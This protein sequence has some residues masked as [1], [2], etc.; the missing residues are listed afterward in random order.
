[1]LLGTG[2]I[3]SE[4]F[5][6][7][8]TGIFLLR[9]YVKIGAAM[10][11]KFQ[12]NRKGKK[13]V[14]VLRKLTESVE[15]FVRKE[16]KSGGV[17][18]EEK[19][20]KGISRFSVKKK[21]R[22]ELRREKRK[23]KKI[24]RKTYCEGKRTGSIKA[25]ETEL[26][27]RGKARSPQRKEFNEVEK[28]IPT[29]SELIR[30]K[31]KGKAVEKGQKKST[32]LESSKR[33]EQLKTKKKSGGRLLETRRLALL[34]ANAEEDRE[35]K[36]L[37]KQLR[38]N[39]RKN[40]K[41]LPQSFVADGLDYVLGILEP[42]AAG[43]GLYES[44]EETE[45][46]G[47]TLNEL[48]G[49]GYDQ[50]E[51]EESEMKSDPEDSELSENEETGESDVDGW[52]EFKQEDSAPS[53]E[54]QNILTTTCEREESKGFPSAQGESEDI[55]MNSGQE[56][57]TE[58]YIPPHLQRS[59]ETIDSKRRE[60]LDRLKRS[61]KGLINRLSEANIA[62]ISSQFEELYMAHS[63]KD[64]NDTLTDVLLVS[65]VI[66]SLMP[67][68]L[69]MEHVLLISIL[70][71]TVGMEVGAHF[72]ETIVRKFDVFHLSSSEGKESDNLL[73]MIAHMYNFN[74]VHCVLMFD[75]LKK[76]LK[77]FTEKDIELI[78]F[79]L[80]NVGFSLRKDDPLALKEVI[81][82]IQCKA[83]SLA[84]RMQEQ[85]RVRF[86]L[87]TLLA[88][89]NNDMRKIPGYDPEPVDRL[90]KLQRTLIHNNASGSDVCLR[91]TLDSLL[92][93]DQVG[94]WWI[95][96]SSWSGAPMLNASDIKDKEI[97]SVGK[98]SAKI[99]E[100]A[101]KQRMNT[102]IRRNIFCVLMT[103]EDFLDA[104]EKLLRLGLK[105]HQQRE[106]VHVLVDCC[107]QEK[108]FNPYYAVLA[109]KF[110]GYDRQFQMT[111]QFTMWDKFRDLTNLSSPAFSNL[112]NL[113]V[114]FLKKA[115]LSLSVLKIIEF[116]ELD[117]VKVRFLRQV[118]SKLLTESEPEDLISIFGRISGIAKL[119]ML[120]EGLKLFISH[121]LLKNM[122]ILGTAEQANLLRERATLAE[123]AL[124]AKDAKLK[125]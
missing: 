100:L 28:S 8:Q 5:T 64:M 14:D 42:G 120:R 55:E 20:F 6:Y 38:L 90:R 79:L 107:L 67:A 53:V 86:M 98:A 108:S 92:T 123:K 22:K 13:H 122:Q 124:E 77:T 25:V 69:L 7:V 46:I 111:I 37:E 49:D 40:K 109:E 76:L 48:V 118:L 30:S 44:D 105:E 115:S 87:E 103:S 112:V 11:R 26:K 104:F 29:S 70:H 72:L 47:G 66:P 99:L 75:I 17:G 110:C 83:G 58:K 97:K 51:S 57:T 88:L 31:V 74:I 85:P 39:K 12:H 32:K 33:D 21:S 81:S 113:L 61:V 63:R 78:L 27:K 121:F 56:G 68:R 119:T 41:S 24:K 1:M 52:E 50:K 59:A 116:S 19:T 94:R 101:R 71:H 84:P 80:K 43:S 45:A 34:E 4:C 54:E 60:E 114:H 65:C 96:G 95:V 35:I 106:I 2:E 10:K 16:G 93:A 117:K 73:A 82:E 23:A 9:C 36:R 89:K 18:D 62:S 125:L 91:V 3:C 102:D 15:E